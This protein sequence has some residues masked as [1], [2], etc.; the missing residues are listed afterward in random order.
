MEMIAAGDAAL[1]LYQVVDPTWSFVVSC[2]WQCRPQ[3]QQTTTMPAPQPV[4]ALDEQAAQLG[5]YQLVDAD[6]N[7][8]VSCDWQCKAEDEEQ[9]QEPPEVAA[10]PPAMAAQPPPARTRCNVP[11][12]ESDARLGLYQLVDHRWNFVV[13]CDWQ[14]KPP[15]RPKSQAQE[16][17][18]DDGVPVHGETAD[19]GTA[20]PLP[21]SDARLGL[22]QLVDRRWE[23][24]VSCEWQCKPA[25]VE[26]EGEG[27]VAA[28]EARSAEV[29]SPSSSLS[30]CRELDTAAGVARR[31]VVIQQAGGGDIMLTLVGDEGELGLVEIDDAQLGSVSSHAASEQQRVSPEIV[32]RDQHAADQRKSRLEQLMRDLGDQVTH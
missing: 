18:V 26:T 4:Q 10:Q 12:S 31:S 28:G 27:V 29:A 32:A 9:P 20:V 22:Y 14:C 13:S 11:L 23:Y 2:D 5:L 25:R 3:D 30:E 6:W 21:E 19:G 16:K 17:Q 24:S 15:R 1:G 8:V 7:F